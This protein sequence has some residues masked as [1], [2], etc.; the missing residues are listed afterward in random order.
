LI[1]EEVPINFFADELTD[2]R[3]TPDALRTLGVR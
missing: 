1:N 3:F 2:E